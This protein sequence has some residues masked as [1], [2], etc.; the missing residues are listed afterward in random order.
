VHNVHAQPESDPERIRA[1]LVE[2]IYSPVQ[3]TRCMAYIAAQGVT[4]VV[5]CGPGKVLSGL[6]KRIDGALQSH[7]LEDPAGM[8]EAL[9]ALA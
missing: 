3:W 6:N 1:L 9:A 4:Q 8:A 7:A 2:Q 5:E